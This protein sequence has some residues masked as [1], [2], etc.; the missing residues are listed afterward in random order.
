MNRWIIFFSILLL[1]FCSC[2]KSEKTEREVII[3]EWIG[4]KIIIPRLSNQFKYDEKAKIVT[5]INGNCF[6]CISKLELWSGFIDE[7]KKT[8]NNCSIHYYFYI[9]GADTTA[10][11]TINDSL[12]RFNLPVIFDPNNT[13]FKLNKLHQ[14]SLY[15]TMLLDSSDKVILIGTPIL[16][17]KLQKLYID[18]IR[19][20][21]S[22]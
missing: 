18:E 15:H 11:K 3:E 1:T 21:N 7:M 16:N 19:R 4:K 5:Q 10:F 12:I 14:N 17:K 13:F 20:I 9:S 6:S 8:C 2:V 22:K